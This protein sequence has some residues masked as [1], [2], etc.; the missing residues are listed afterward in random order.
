MKRACKLHVKLPKLIHM[1]GLALDVEK[2]RKPR[3]K[4]PSRRTPGPLPSVHQ[5]RL[6]DFF[7][8]LQEPLSTSTP[9]LFAPFDEHQEGQSLCQS[10]EC[11]SDER[12]LVT[13][14]YPWSY[15]IPDANDIVFRTKITVIVASPARSRY[16]SMQYASLICNP[17]VFDRAIPHMAKMRPSQ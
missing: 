16:V 15:A 14:I 6:L 8:I 7:H 1:F 10:S 3:L 11:C 12:I 5:S 9:P 13:H 2:H 17:I 4:I